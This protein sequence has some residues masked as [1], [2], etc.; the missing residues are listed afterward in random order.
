MYHSWNT[1]VVNK[2]IQFRTSITSSNT[3]IHQSTRRDH[4]NNKIKRQSILQEPTP[5][6]QIDPS[7]PV[8]LSN[9]ISKL[10]E[11]NID[12]RYQSAKGLT[13]DIDLIISEYKPGVDL[14]LG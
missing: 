14:V 8:P 10:M 1:N 12:F 2:N 5:I 4:N 9:M 13:H 11:K 7:I 6:H 3:A